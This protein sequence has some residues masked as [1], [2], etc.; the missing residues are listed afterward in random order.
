[1][2][3]VR[4]GEAPAVIWLHG[5][6]QGRGKSLL[7][8]LRSRLVPEAVR[9]FNYLFLDGREVPLERILEMARSMPMLSGRRLVVVQNA[10]ELRKTDLERSLSYFEKPCPTTCLVF[11]AQR[12][13]QS[14][15][16]A[17]LLGE[18]GALL[19]LR[20]RSEQEA[21]SWVRNRVRKEGKDITAEACR[22][23]IRR[24]GTHEGVLEGE[25]QK[26][27]AFAGEKTLIQDSDVEDV[28][29]EARSSTLFQLTDA[30]SEKRTADAVRILHRIL[31]QGTAPLAVVGMLA[32]QLRLLLAA[33]GARKGSPPPAQLQ[34]PRF[35]W[36]RLLLQARLWSEPRLLAALKALLEVDEAMKSGRLDP[37]VLLDR[38]AIRVALAR[39]N[40]SGARPQGPSRRK[41][42]AGSAGR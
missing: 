1:M 40:L 21:Q 24:A 19:E 15:R 30:L 35:V 9:A 18:K 20:A 38:W 32:R 33:L 34:V 25:V 3:G 13:P 31:E 39:E 11:W 16:L 41:V 17:R 14:E 23:L 28:A 29:A 8:E 22:A 27:L 42:P 7:E 12:P 2:E 37:E 26:L 4:K 6:D 10:S 36:D 5:E